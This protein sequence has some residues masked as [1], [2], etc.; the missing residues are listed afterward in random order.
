MPGTI[1]LFGCPVDG[2]RHLSGMTS[3]APGPGELRAAWRRQA[4]AWLKA[5]HPADAL[6]QEIRAGIL[7]Q[8]RNILAEQE[9]DQAVV[10]R[11]LDE[12]DIPLPTLVQRLSEITQAMA[13]LEP[14]TEKTAREAHSLA[15]T[16]EEIGQDQETLLTHWRQ[17]RD[18]DVVPDHTERYFATLLAVREE[19]LERAKT[20]ARTD[21]PE[22]FAYWQTRRDYADTI[23][24]AYGDDRDLIRQWLLPPHAPDASAAAPGGEVRQAGAEGSAPQLRSHVTVTR[25]GI[26]RTGSASST[27]TGLGL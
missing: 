21:A 16:S 26:T 14:G 20:R 4:W 8:E 15:V 1:R 3:D 27:G 9:L 12:R 11:W 25:T 24:D 13:W 17:G 6:R 7:W 18:L 22:Q 19:R 23:G 2:V 10:E 5:V